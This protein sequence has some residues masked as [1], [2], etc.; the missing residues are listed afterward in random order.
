MTP[1]NDAEKAAVRDALQRARQQARSRG[2]GTAPARVTV[3]AP[4]GSR[5]FVDGVPCPVRTFNTPALQPGRDYYYDFRVE[6]ARDGQTQTQN[7]RVT[8]AAGR[9]VTV[10]FAA[11]P[12]AGIARR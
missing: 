3:N 9:Q 11:P 7:R 10:D 2:N 1:K 12:P 6:M 5:V 4:A 8:V